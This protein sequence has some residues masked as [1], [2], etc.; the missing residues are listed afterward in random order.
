MDA[1]AFEQVDGAFQDFHAKK[2]FKKLE[3]VPSGG[4]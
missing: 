3:H 1:A 4:A 2:V